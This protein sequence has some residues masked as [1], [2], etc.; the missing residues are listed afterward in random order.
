M[1]SPVNSS[2]DLAVACN[3]LNKFYEHQ[4]T[5]QA[6]IPGGC[7]DLTFTINKFSCEKI[8]NGLAISVTS[9][10]GQEA[11]YKLITPLTIEEQEGGLYEQR[12]DRRVRSIVMYAVK[13][14]EQGLEYFALKRTWNPN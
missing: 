14:D 5:Y 6:I 12:L 10:L 3:R 13:P 4:G 9:G 1:A 8:N 2:D 11:N 7:F